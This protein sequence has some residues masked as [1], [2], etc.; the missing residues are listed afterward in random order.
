MLKASTPHAYAAAVRWVHVPIVVLMVALA[1][2]A[3][4]YLDAG[5]RWLA[6]TAIGLRLVSLVINFT[7]GENL[8]W[9]EVQ[10]LRERLV[11]RRRGPGSGRREQPLDGDRPARRAR[12]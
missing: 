2:F 5:R 11:P 8:N 4:H 1:G 9:L 12:C 6:A 3:F 7:V 10:A